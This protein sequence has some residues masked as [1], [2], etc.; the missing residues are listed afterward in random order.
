MR[1][2]LDWNKKSLP[3]LLETVYRLEVQDLLRKEQ[4]KSKKS[5]Q[6]GKEMNSASKP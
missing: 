5:A 6:R 3:D 2:H 4:K 1:T